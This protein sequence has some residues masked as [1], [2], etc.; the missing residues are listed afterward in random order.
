MKIL[1]L[2]IETAP[3]KVYAW[4]LFSTD[5]PIKNIIE[6]GYTM[7]FAAKFLGSKRMHFESIQKDKESMVQ[8]AWDLLDE[9]DVV[10]HYNGKKF[11]IPHLQK[12][13]ILAGLSPPSPFREVDLL[14]V[15]RRKF[16]FAS[17]KLDHVSQAL[18]LEAK[19]QHKGVELWHE[20][21]EGNPKAWRE[22]KKYNV[23]DVHLLEPLYRTLLPWIENHPNWNTYL[24]NSEFTC[25]NCGSTNVE[26]RGYAH[27]NTSVYKRFRCK[28]AGCGRWSR[29]RIQE[30]RPAEG[31]LT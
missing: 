24:R 21:M 1:L 6:P 30:Q 4:G 28:E 19:V 20:C 29:A 22:M 11:D 7:C 9:A 27:T 5:I 17:N 31:T 13:F 12:E 3:H 23:Q 2:D 18:G 15:V 26:H 16:K 14:Q 8:R 10:V 25:R